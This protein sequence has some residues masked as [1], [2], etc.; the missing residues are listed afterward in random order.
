ME[1]VLVF[2]LGVALLAIYC[3]AVFLVVAAVQAEVERRRWV[4]LVAAQF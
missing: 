3:L 4:C 1:I 2:V